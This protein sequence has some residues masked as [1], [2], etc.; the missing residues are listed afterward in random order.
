MGRAATVVAVLAIICAAF[1]FAM[2]RGAGGDTP[3]VADALS[4]EH[5]AG[6]AG[7][8]RLDE[9]ARRAEG[10]VKGVP[11]EMLGEAG[12]MLDPAKRNEMLGF[13]PLKA[14][15][16]ATVGIDPAAGVHVAL[17]GRITAGGKPI[18]VLL[19]RVTDMTK[20]L[21]FIEKR[22]G[23]KPEVSG[24]GAVKTVKMAGKSALFGERKGY[25]AVLLAEGDVASGG[26]KKGFEAYLAGDEAALSTLGPFKTGFGG[27]KAPVVFSYADLKGARSLAAELKA[28][29]QALAVIDY[30]VG[31]FPGAAMWMGL[32]S[33]GFRLVASE[34]GVALLQKF[35]RPQ[36]SAPD[37][38]KYIPAKGWGAV[39][40]SANLPQLLDAVAEA[41]PPDLPQVTKI[42]QGMQ[43]G[44][45]MMG[46]VIGVTWDQLGKAFS[47][48]VAFAADLATLEK[49]AQGGAFDAVALIGVN[50][51][52]QADTVVKTLLDKVK[53]KFPIPF[54]VKRDGDVLVLGI[55]S[56]VD[57]AIKRAGGK[58]TLKGHPTAS[59]LGDDVVYGATYDVTPLLAQLAKEAPELKGMLDSPAMKTLKADPH[60][61]F[62][63]R[64]DR[65]GLIGESIGSAA[66]LTTMLGAM[67]GIAIPA[68]VKYINKS[69][70]AEAQVNL[71]RMSD[72]ATAFYER[73]QVSETGELLPK[74]FPVSASLTPADPCRKSRK[75]ELI[76]AGAWKAKGWQ[77][78]RFQVDGPSYYSYEFVSQ[79]E[80]TG[81]TFTARVHGDL[82]CDGTRSTFERIGRVGPGGSVMGGAGMFVDNETE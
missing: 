39:K 19:V 27:A 10:A 49:I 50:D 53:G 62:A 47:G 76:P 5:T 34:K 82:D 79:G 73:E 33:T 38:A 61:A 52:E 43:A 45:L 16:W 54:V 59:A 15:G 75:A 74:R 30:Y 3:G 70:A 71:R 24:D 14:E 11:T 68:F 18:P 44:V 58:D 72:A 7:I 32:E 65:N 2:F 21:A 57:A 26:A 46:E 22:A 80:G 55:A 12:A 64:L 23:Q 29:P 8:Q 17:D 41:L 35:F 66:S 20:L 40:L 81:A 6:V 60:V 31:L 42:K 36:R 48:H 78:L 13:D 25:T 56:S 51:P 69:K 77:E 4:A 63:L 1:Y 28:P 37:F 9:L 67:A